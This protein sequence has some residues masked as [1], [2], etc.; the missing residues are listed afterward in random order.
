[1]L[2][3]TLSSFF[4]FLW[5]NESILIHIHDIECILHFFKLRVF[6]FKANG[7]WHNNFDKLGWLW[8]QNDVVKYIC[9]ILLRYCLGLLKKSIVC[10]PIMLQQVLCL[11]SLF[12][13]YYCALLDEINTVCAESVFEFIV[14]HHPLCPQY[15]LELLN[16]HITVGALACQQF[17]HDNS[18]APNIYFWI[19][20]LLFYYFWRHIKRWA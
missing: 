13:R 16:I 4:K 10:N 8:I 6:K 1:M 14:Q 20:F 5:L 15:P 19:V 7:N 18:N 2:F 11:L 3:K 9:L 12:W 17:I